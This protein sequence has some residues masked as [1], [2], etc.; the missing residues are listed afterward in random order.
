MKTIAEQI[1]SFETQLAADDARMSA[2]MSK[3]ADEGRTLD[4]S[5]TEEYDGLKVKRQ[6]VIDHVNRLK[7][8][9]KTIVAKATPIVPD[10]G[11]DPKKGADARGGVVQVNSLVPKGIGFARAA[12]ALMACKGNRYEATEQAK[13]HWPDMASDLEV[14][15]KAEQLPGTTTGTTWAAP[16]IVTANRLTDEF[17]ALLRPASIIGRV[18]GLRRVPFN[19]SVPAQTGGGTYQWVGEN[20]PKPVS[21]LALSTVTLRW[22]KVAGII[23]FTKEAMKFSNPSIE[24]IVRDDMVRGTAQYLD[25]QFIDPAVH[26]SVNVSPASITDQIVNTAASGTTAA[27]FRNDFKNILGKFIT[28]NEDPTTAVILMSATVA[29]NLSS[30][31]NALGQPEFPTISM[32]GGTYL[33]IPIIVSQ[34][35]GNRIILVNPSEI[36][37][38]QEDSVTID[39]SE[40]ASVVMTTTPASSPQATSLVSF[41]QNNL[42]GLRVEQF[43]TWKR[44]VTT[45][46]EYISGASYSG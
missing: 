19:V 7:D 1:L 42:I 15:L 29:M 12:I 2:I 23:P 22:A 43:I 3:S 13:K 36:L 9:E 18:T 17:L 40:E 30:L 8:H 24:A 37:I 16:L 46:V 14:I 21:G 20:V 28:N 44:A 45:A 26:E 11:A 34:A 10:A 35:V 41:W 5:E 33:G 25:Q 32:Q 39:I 4:T 27:L 6:T 31:M 38:A